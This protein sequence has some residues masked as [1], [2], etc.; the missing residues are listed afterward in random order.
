MR[1]SLL[2]DS[3]P[4][5]IDGVA[6]V[7]LNYADIMVK[8]NLAEVMVGTPEYPGTDYSVYPYMVCPY[9]SFD[10]T[11]IAS[12][13][14]TGTP[15]DLVELKNMADFNPDIIHVHCPMTSAY[16][17]RM[18]RARVDAP[19][20]FTYHTKYDEDIAKV[21][22]SDFL[23][24]ETA[25]ALVNNIEACDEIWVVS[26][27][28]GENLK[29][30]GFQGDYRVMGNGV[31][32]AKGRVDEKTVAEVTR[33]YDLPENLPVFLFVGRIIDYK[34]IGLI[35][36]AMSILK[37]AGCD[38]RMVFVGGG[39][40]LEKYKKLVE[41]RGLTEDSECGK[42]IF[43]G[44]VYDRDVLRA[45]N[46]RADM[47]VFPSTF[48][49][50]GIVVREAAACGLAS[51][52]IK[53]SCAAEGITDGRNGYLIDKTPEDIAKLLMN[54]VTDLD[55][56]HDVGQ[57]AMDEI[58]ISWADCVHLAHRR[59]GELIDLHESG[60]LE[61]NRKIKLGMSFDT[62][63]DDVSAAISDMMVKPMKSFD[64]MMDN[65]GDLA[66]NM[67]SDME[68]YFQIKYNKFRRTIQDGKERSRH[69]KDYF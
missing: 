52:L 15:F 40:D 42:C 30:L 60:L 10:T 45:W 56:V 24:K 19:I 34:G 13:Y 61:T 5:V 65:I 46:T 43:T 41:E 59:Y 21:V 16:V 28:A 23:R 22:K 57:H 37:E 67:Y 27:G 20:V 6:N 58:Y 11:K 29:S 14:R 17:A 54:V 33:E 26:E 32:F 7:V 50:N 51:I 66:E 35:I 44:P 62:M 47:F 36:D 39:P 25:K 69:G 9:K 68:E 4:P 48:D 1:V 49:T 64:D 18:L 31:D 8:E 55:K 2:N 38:F 63:S 12:G 3:F 53:G